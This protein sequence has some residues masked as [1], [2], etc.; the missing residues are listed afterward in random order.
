M[1]KNDYNTVA[2]I[3]SERDDIGM[4]CASTPT[5]ARGI[6]Y[7]MCTD[8]RPLEAGGMGYSE[9]YIPSQKNP[10]FTKEMDERAKSECTDTQYQHEILAEFGTE[11]SGVFD[12]TQVDAAMKK[13]FYYYN[14]LSD[15]QKRNLKDDFQPESFIYD[16]DN[17]A[18]YNPF[19]CMGVD[20]DAVQAGSSLLVLDFDVNRKSFKVIKTI[21]V[22]RS[23][24]TLDNAVNWIIKLNRI[25]NP[26]WIFCDRGFGGYKFK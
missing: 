15:M 12:K 8:K 13:E 20:W 9:H 25:Y 10:M 23:E 16:E 14:P 1:G 3:A 24:Y 2:M 21:E 6:F 26:S 22:P 4:T 11:E 5:G 7:R 17:P 18:P 19:R